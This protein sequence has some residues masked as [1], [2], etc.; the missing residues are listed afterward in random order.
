MQVAEVFSPT[1]DRISNGREWTFDERQGATVL[2]P[3]AARRARD[4][5][6]TATRASAQRRAASD[7]N[8]AARRAF[9]RLHPCP[10]TGATTGACPGY[11]VD[12]IVPLKDGGPDLPANMQWQ[13]VDEAKAKDRIE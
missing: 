6:T 2:E 12:H 10:A 13:S 1:K 4:H 7:S 9:I 11:V 3:A 8:S 5:G